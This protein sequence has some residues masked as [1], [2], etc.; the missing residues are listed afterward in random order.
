MCQKHNKASI[1][2]LY[3]KDSLTEHVTRSRVQQHREQTWASSPLFLLFFSHRIELKKK[4]ENKKGAKKKEKECG[5][6][7]SKDPYG[8]Y[9]YS[10]GCLRV[11]DVRGSAC[12]DHK[13][14]T[15]YGI[16]ES[17]ALEGN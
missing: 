3:K 11:L 1:I 13:K 7:W 14:P 8:N 15:P 2:S 17:H 6:A 12:Q 5:G 4:I 9:S 10:C 16:H